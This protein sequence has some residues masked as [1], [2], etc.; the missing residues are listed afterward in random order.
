[1]ALIGGF[2]HLLTAEIGEALTA[3]VGATLVSG[4]L[5]G[6]VAVVT[7]AWWLERVGL[8]L[9]GVGWLGVLPAAI[10]RALTVSIPGPVWMVVALIIIA[11]ADA[12]KRY[13]RIEWA[14]LDPER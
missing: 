10:S 13:K 12:F 6:A 4:G 8:L 9:V 1:M 11:L 7:G 3:L 5:V 14:Y 2:P